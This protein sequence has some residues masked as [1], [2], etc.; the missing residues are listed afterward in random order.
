M[1]RLLFRDAITERFKLKF[2]K[3]TDCRVAYENG[4][5]VDLNTVTV[6]VISYEIIYENSTQAD[7]HEQPQ[8]LDT[9]SVLVNILVRDMA[10]NRTAYA[11]REEVAK[12]LQR[13]HIADAVMQV[14]QPLP[15]SHAVKGWVGY[16]VA[17][18][19]WHYH[20]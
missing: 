15:N 10:G 12:L 14:G 17:V 20:F 19:F 1:D 13:Q 16:R 2:E 9:G 5:K 6:P 18:P 7:L 8:T 3:R 11:L 4:P